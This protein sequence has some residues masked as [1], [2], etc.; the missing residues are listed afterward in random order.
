MRSWLFFGREDPA[1]SDDLD[2]TAT[3]Q[4]GFKS[5]L[6]CGTGVGIAASGVGVAMTDPGVAVTVCFL[7]S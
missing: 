2:P 3:R 6:N 1:E 4:R 7:L 5:G